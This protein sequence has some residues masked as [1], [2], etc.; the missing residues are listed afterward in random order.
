M[1]F[2][3]FLLIG[4]PLLPLLGAA[5]AYSL[6]SGHEKLAFASTR[7]A[8]FLSFLGAVFLVVFSSGNAPVR[9]V[10]FPDPF[11]SVPGPGMGLLWDPLAA[12]MSFLILSVSLTIQTFSYRYMS[13]EPRAGA[14]L[15]GFSLAT[16]FLLILVTARN[17]VLLYAAWELVL[18][19]LCLLLIH[20]RD[21]RE[22][23]RPATRTW[24]MNQVGGGIF[25]SGILVLGHSFGTFDLDGL[26]M[27]L[28]QSSAP[29]I[30]WA[31]YDVSPV[32]LAGF[33]IGLGIL[34]RSAQFPFHL[35]LP[36]TLDA[37]TPVSGF[38][39]AGIVNAGGFIL[40]RL[41]PVFLHSPNVLH[42]LFLVGAFTAVMGSAVMLVQANV[43][44]TLVFSTMG[45]MGYMIAECGLGVFPAAIFHMIAHGIFK[46]T[47]FLG[48]GGVIHAARF[49]E[50]SPK[51]SLFRAFRRHRIAWI[52]AGTLLI[53]LPIFLLLLDAFRGKP[54]LP[55][56]G[57]VILLF[58]GLATAMQTVFNLFRFSH[59]LTP[60]SVVI[61]TAV[62]GLIFGLY[63]GGLHWFD[64]LLEPM[65]HFSAMSTKD[66]G[67]AFFYPVTLA[68]MG[69]ILVVGWIF[70]ARESPASRFLPSRSPWTDRLHDLLDQGLFGESLMR[71]FIVHP[72]MRLSGLVR[73]I[74]ERLRVERPPVPDLEGDL[75]A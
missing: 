28:H 71:R 15:G 67:W 32:G 70:L 47:L 65:T 72:I 55:G 61:F 22:S 68:T 37:P 3:A 62:F 52:I 48:S 51:G 43:K 60:R 44:Q 63:W 2:S 18:V 59:L 9:A 17:L 25:L 20:H 40:N 54:F 56:R 29:I 42:G 35:W 41:S 46:A 1:P 26:F 8:T 38:M 75:D 39:H 19:A 58:F 53:S 6:P 13:G 21:R 10:L 49:H 7:G 66:H 57:G 5:V 30:S 69:F 74:H 4:V 12:I 16:G 14:F 34:V 24:V 23:S 50:H 33:L 64:Q 31:G 45:Q 36:L 73:R 11:S 27:S